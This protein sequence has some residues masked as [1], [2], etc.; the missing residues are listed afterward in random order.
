M[1]PKPIRGRLRGGHTNHYTNDTLKFGCMSLNLN[2]V[3]A[4]PMHGLL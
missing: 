3:G 1:G 2:V 4:S